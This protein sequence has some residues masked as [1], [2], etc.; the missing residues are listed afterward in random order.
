MINPGQFNF[1]I[2]SGGTFGFQIN[3]TD[4]AGTPIDLTGY[5]A[6]MQVRSSVNSVNPLMTLSTSNGQIII[7]TPSNGQIFLSVSST[8]TAELPAGNYVYDL[9]MTNGSG[10]KD[11]LIQGKVV[12]EK[13][14]T[15]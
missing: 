13:M 3:W 5:S 1:S 4:S 14:N 6:K 7:P 9:Q 12:I 8:E 2:L 15:T 11:Y 10:G